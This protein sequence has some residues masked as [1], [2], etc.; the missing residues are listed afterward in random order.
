MAFDAKHGEIV[1]FGGFH[2]EGSPTWYADT[3]LWDTK[4]WHE[5]LTPAPP[6]AR[7][8]HVLAYHAVR[9][10]IFMIGGA[11]GKDVTATTWN[12]DFRKET[13]MWNGKAWVQEFPENQPGPAYTVV[14]AYDDVKQAV[15]VHLG[16]D[17]TC[18]SRGPKTFLLK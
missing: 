12:Y 18:L 17:L 14:A 8:G 9:Q 5:A 7:S 15:T 1:L 2:S 13:W 4:G 6:P 10:S 11:G 3:W 16:D